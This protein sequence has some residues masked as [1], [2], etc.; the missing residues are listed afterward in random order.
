MC[1]C[2]EFAD[3]RLVLSVELNF[4]NSLAKL[5]Q[6]ISSAIFWTTAHFKFVLQAEFFAVW[7]NHPNIENA[8]EQYILNHRSENLDGAVS[9]WR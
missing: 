9:E 4:R 5:G 2:K 8:K 1:C 6:E 7:K 3:W